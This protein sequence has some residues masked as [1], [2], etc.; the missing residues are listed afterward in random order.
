MHH[1][2]FQIFFDTTENTK[3][4]HGCCWEYQELMNN[5]LLVEKKGFI[6]FCLLRTFSA[7]VAD[8]CQINFHLQQFIYW[9]A[10]V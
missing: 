6:L 4:Y 8:I 9:L 10:I 3:K 7:S 2:K 1:N 5:Q